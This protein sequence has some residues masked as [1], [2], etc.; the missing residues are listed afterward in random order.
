MKA[1]TK[2]FVSILISVLFLVFSILIYSKLI[3]PLFAD[4][5]KERGIVA[6]KDEQYKNFK[7]LSDNF[8]ALDQKYK[9]SAQFVA[10]LNEAMPLD[11]E[12]PSEINQITAL[13][14]IA[15]S[16]VGSTAGN[17]RLNSIT[18]KKDALIPSKNPTVMRGRGVVKFSVNMTGTY[19]SFKQYLLL[20]EQNSRLISINNMDFRLDPQNAGS[21]LIDLSIDV[22]YQIK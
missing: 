6:Q 22:F 18:I 12:I 14:G 11:P 1:T 13:I 8:K 3:T 10:A 7:K 20:L 16:T 4:I 21:F 15:N 17:L 19:E 9:N 5:S 2:R